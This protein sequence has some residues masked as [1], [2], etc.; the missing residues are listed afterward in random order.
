MLTIYV[1]S[2]IVSLFYL[3]TTIFLCCSSFMCCYTSSNDGDDSEQ[4]L[5]ACQEDFP[6]NRVGST[7]HPFDL[8]RVHNW[9][10]IIRP[11]IKLGILHLEKSLRA[12]NW[13]TPCV[14]QMSTRKELIPGLVW[15]G[16]HQNIQETDCPTQYVVYAV[17]N[18]NFDFYTRYMCECV[19]WHCIYM[20]S[21]AP[22]Y[23][24]S[25]EKGNT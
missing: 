5:I 13:K 10:I 17:K 8:K 6:H 23:I 21:W 24:W 25:K 16:C 9:K 15:R 14:K 1:Q 7:C 12:T 20:C 19:H 3:T 11:Q 18:T 2:E 22:P 4:R